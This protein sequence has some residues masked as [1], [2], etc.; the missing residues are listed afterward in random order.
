[1]AASSISIELENIEWTSFQKPHDLP[2]CFPWQSI[3]KSPLHFIYHSDSCRTNLV[4]RKY[5]YLSRDHIVSNQPSIP[6]SHLNYAVWFLI[7]HGKFCSVVIPSATNIIRMEWYGYVIMLTMSYLQPHIII[8]QLDL[9]F[10]D[11]S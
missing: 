11:W 4:G 9:Q 7:D 3:Y 1:M 5:L 8:I 2:S 10:E 6:P